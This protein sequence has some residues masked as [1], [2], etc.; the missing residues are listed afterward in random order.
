MIYT[1]TFSPAI[2]YVV[3][4]DELKQGVTNRT[5]GEDYYFGGKGINVST[6][7]NELGIKNTALGFVSGFTGDALENGLKEKG[8]KTDFVHLE[9]G[10]TRINIKIKTSQETEINAQGPAIPEDK[11]RELLEKLSRL[12]K[13]D[14][15]VISGNVPNTLPD[16]IYETI[17]NILQG[18]EIEYVVDATGE[19]LENVLKYKPFFVKPNKAELEEL[20]GFDIEGDEALRRGAGVLQSKGARNV[21]VSLGEEG[22]Y[23]LCE[24]GD[25]YSMKMPRQKVKNTV[26]AGDSLVAGFLAGY[27]NYGDMRIALKLGVAA[28]TATA[29]SED[30]ATRNEIRELYLKMEE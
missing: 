14:F 15:L 2:D 25:E 23:L 10:I 9:E 11:I 4:M 19:L 6:V 27:E 17:I 21:I 24:N 7:L 13:G 26:G 5:V 8:I 18:K 12:K 30:L 16:D 1:V 20:V 22:A 28:G 3:Y 29:C